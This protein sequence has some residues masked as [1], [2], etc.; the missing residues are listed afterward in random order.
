MSAIQSGDDRNFV[1]ER[2]GMRRRMDMTSDETQKSTTWMWLLVA[3]V[4]VLG[5]GTSYAA[6]HL[7]R[8][9]S[10]FAL[11]AIESEGHVRSTRQ[12]IVRYLSDVSAAQGENIFTLDIDM[13]RASVL[14]HP[15]IKDVQVRRIVP[16]TLAVSV[17]EHEPY[18]VV[19]LG[20]LYYVDRDAEPF[21][22]AA[23]NDLGE[24]P[25]L[26]GLEA[27]LY[28]DDR[29]S[30]QR[31]VHLG[32][33]FNDAAKKNGLVVGEIQLDP[34]HGVIAHLLPSGTTAT[35]GTG[36]FDLKIARL[37]DVRAL[38]AER[39]QVAESY[40]L[41]NPRRPDAVVARLVPVQ[42]QKANRTQYLS[43]R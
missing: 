20:S 27:S 30:W 26:T 40:L 33:Q 16:G 28:E 13:L 24:L 9:S 1:K 37:R 8:Q 17:T 34:A 19:A 43:A 31:L 4:M 2:A 32:V 35:F 23:V 11:R 39:G 38:L 41:D 15:W 3:A 22:R 21:A 18:A 10:L 7:M 25:V 5:A 12:E 29:P 42:K 14:R 6:W 36:D